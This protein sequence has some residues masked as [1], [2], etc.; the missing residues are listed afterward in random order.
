MIK[1]N[2]KKD[3]L[4]KVN[5]LLQNLDQKSMTEVLK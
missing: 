1:L 5:D 4:R 3:S 2:L